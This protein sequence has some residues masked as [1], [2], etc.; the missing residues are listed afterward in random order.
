LKNGG[1]IAA[2]DID[3]LPFDKICP[4]II[5][6]PIRLQEE[7]SEQSHRKGRSRRKAVIEAPTIQYSAHEAAMSQVRQIIRKSSRK[8]APDVEV[9]I[10]TLVPKV[11]VLGTIVETV[12]PRVGSQSR[13]S[14]AQSSP[15]LNLSRVVVRCQTVANERNEVGGRVVGRLK[16]ILLQ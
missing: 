1:A 9:A 11:G 4:P 2:V 14:L 5:K 6:L 8:V 10:P 12:R 3:R 16:R 15:K 7:V 13:Q